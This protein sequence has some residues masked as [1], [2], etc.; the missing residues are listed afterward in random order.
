MPQRKT[1]GL[2]TRERL[3]L[4]YQQK[5]PNA[6]E[7]LGGLGVGVQL[8]ELKPRKLASARETKRSTTM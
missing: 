7:G 8:G 2:M 4:D 5:G 1:R 6:E 3:G